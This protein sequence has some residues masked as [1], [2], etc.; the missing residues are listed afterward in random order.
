V[1]LEVEVEDVLPRPVQPRARFDL[2][3]IDPTAGELADALEQGGWLVGGGEDDRGLVPLRSGWI[4][5]AQDEEPGVVE[6]VVLDVAVEDL[7][8]AQLRCCSPGDHPDPW[9]WIFS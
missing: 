9:N 8:A 6:R 3:Q 1:P 7:K 5:R 4:F 2:R